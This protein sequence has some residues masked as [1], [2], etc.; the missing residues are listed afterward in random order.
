[1]PALSRLTVPTEGMAFDP[2]TG[3]TFVINDSGVRILKAFQSGERRDDIVHMLS[4][5]YQ[6]R[7]EDA[8]RDVD[9]F[10]GR[11]RNLQLV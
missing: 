1:M 11:L 6:I 3:D 2:S 8:E 10:Q 4:E 5:E 9:D 7:E